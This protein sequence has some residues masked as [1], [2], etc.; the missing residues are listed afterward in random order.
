[1][2]NM[3]M[4]TEGCFQDFSEIVTVSEQ[5]NSL[6]IAEKPLETKKNH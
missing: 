3:L 1:M 6:H 2:E 4:N 5:N